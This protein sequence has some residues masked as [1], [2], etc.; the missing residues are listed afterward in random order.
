MQLVDEDK[1]ALETPVMPF[2]G[3][4]GTKISDE[5]T[6]YH[7]LTHTSGIDDDADEEAGEDYELLLVGTP[8]YS[9]RET[10]DFLPQFAWKDPVFAPG[11][12]VRYNNCAYVLLG[13]GIEK[14]SGLS[15][16]DYARR[17]VFARAGM[18]G[19]DFLVM[20]SVAP[21]MA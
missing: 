11:V 17:N 16:R 21:N 3:I 14:V 15:Y 20:D 4:E 13:L 8:N 19:A 7:C 18:T 1:I 5:V 12:G 10:R 2:L 6:V 9:I